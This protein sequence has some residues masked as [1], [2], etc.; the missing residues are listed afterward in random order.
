MNIRVRSSTGRRETGVIGTSGSGS[1]FD[2][3]ATA[4]LGG[5]SGDRGCCS[6]GE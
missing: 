1:R 5:E 4:E 6:T 2:G 3:G